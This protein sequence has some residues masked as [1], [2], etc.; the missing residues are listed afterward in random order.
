MIGK[1][2]SHYKILGKLGEG[3]MGVVYKAEDT[4]LKRI[5]ALKFLPPEFTR[6][7]DA[8]ERFFVEAQAAAALSHSNIVTVHEV[9]EYENQ[10]Y[11]A[12][13]YIEGQNL[14]DKIESGPLQIEESLKIAIQIAEGLQ[15]AHEKGIVHRDI[16]GANIMVTEKNQVKIMDFGLAKLKGKSKL[17]KAGTTVGTASYMSPEQSMGKKVD[18]RTD[19]W[20]LGVVLYEMITGQLPFKGDY[21]QAVVYSI[22]N[23]EPEPVTAIRTGIPQEL[24]RI[25]NKTLVKDP[26]GRFQHADE[27]ITDMQHLKKEL[28][29]KRSKSKVDIM[30]EPD[31]K[32]SKRIKQYAVLVAILIIIVAT[33]FIVTKILPKE[34]TEFKKKAESKWENSIAV[35]PFVDLS[36]EKDQ[37]Y[38]CDGMTEQIISNLTRLKKLKVIARTSVMKF[39]NTNKTI[40]QIG[41]ELNTAYVLEGSLRKAA[42]QIRITAQL[43]NVK[44]GFHLWSDDYTRELKNI[45]DIQD[46]ISGK[47]GNA[48][49]EKLSIK[50][51]TAIKTKRPANLEA[52][53]YYLRGLHYHE[54]KYWQEIYISKE[55]AQKIFNIAE[56]MFKKAIELDPDY[57]LSYAGL[58]DLYDSYSHSQVGEAKKNILSYQRNIQ[59]LLLI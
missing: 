23:E 53:N 42:N 52:Y 34:E 36:P 54:K 13:E 4:K 21:E 55:K 44:D 50:E 39:K 46:D 35:L 43:I 10:I 28:E 2:I 24:E 51:T 38:F 12:T 7:K 45:F 17:T 33:Y 16:K 40:P 27:F 15:E 19:I 31:S 30:P 59:R 56:Q 3:G 25:I 9:D 49:L 20:S 5:V 47:I 11:I 18:H 8:K 26:S 48:L 29:L 41:S 1:T 6:D 32:R 22:L 37:E 57:A 14:K 58:A